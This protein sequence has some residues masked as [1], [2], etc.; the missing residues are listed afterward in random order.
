MAPCAPHLI[1]GSLDHSTQHPRLNLDRHSHFRTAQSS[2]SLYFTVDRHF[3]LQNCPFAW[4]IWTGPH[5]IHGSL[6]PPNS[7]SQTTSR[8]VQPFLQGSRL[9]QTDTDGQTDRQTDR[10]TD[11]PHYSICNNK[12]HL[13]STVMHPNEYRWFCVK[14]GAMLV[15]SDISAMSSELTLWHKK[16]DHWPPL[17]KKCDKYF[18]W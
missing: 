13:C 2:E 17:V 3:P 11:K 12:Q 8:L 15:F 6:G 4:G 5:L 9:W 7:T 14:T 18:T 16:L 1:H 10:R